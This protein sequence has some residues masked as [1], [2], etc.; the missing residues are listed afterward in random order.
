M[1][2]QE[3]VVNGF[4]SLKEKVIELG[5]CTKCGTC[6]SVCP[7]NSIKIEELPKLSGPCMYCGVCYDFCPRS[8]DMDELIRIEVLGRG[9]GVKRTDGV[10]DYLEAF[11]ARTKLEEV[12]RV[13]QDGGIVSSILLYLFDKGEIDGAVLT[14]ADE[15]WRSIPFVATD[16]EGV[17][18]AAGTSYV[19]APTVQMLREAVYGMSLSKIAV[20]GVP[21][22]M[23]GLAKMRALPT[24]SD[25]ARGV[26]FTIGIF[27]MESFDHPTLI[28]G[29][30]KEKGYSPK[31]IG[32]FAIT[33]G[34]FIAYKKDGSVAVEVPVK[35]VAHV[36]RGACH[37]CPDLTSEHAEISVGSIGS[38]DGWSTVIIRSEEGRRVFHEAA[39]A[40]YLEFSPLPE[41]GME[42]LKK[43]AKRKKKNAKKHTEELLKKLLS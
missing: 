32:K 33:K 43:I 3:I 23:T 25:I 26:R 41:K 7:L 17:L 8:Y 39:E 36:A 14:K 16:R 18:E 22:Q 5:R 40:G 38:E 11:T 1:S 27:C 19:M 42:L 34:K 24:L 6:A 31:D 12:R 29:Y 28:E 13:A 37:Y 9:K 35:E 30:L 21:C 4:E 2:L 20:V 10:G 15:E